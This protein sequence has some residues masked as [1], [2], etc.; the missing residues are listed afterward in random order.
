MA[1]ARLPR[2][3]PVTAPATVLGYHGC[4]LE[5]AE[6]ILLEQRFAVSENAYDWLGRGIY[7]WEYAP[8]RALEWARRKYEP[9]G[10]EPAVIGVTIRLGQCLNLLDIQHTSDLVG[11]YDDLVTSI[12]FSKLPQNTKSGAHFLDRRIIDSFCRLD[13]EQT[14]NPIQT[15]RGSF[16]EG[17]PLYP[18]SKILELAHV[19]IAVTD[20]RCLSRLHLVNFS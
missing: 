18:G 1:Q 8:Y 14:I 16:P 20:A 3:R 9:Q 6:K 10:I 15:V 2:R 11:V 5:T 13:E 19:Q 7:F 4:S 17:Q 12:G